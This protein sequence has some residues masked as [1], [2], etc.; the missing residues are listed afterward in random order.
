MRFAF[1]GRVSTEDHQDPVTSRARQ[2]DQAVALVGGHGRM[3]AEYVD[4]GHSRVLPWARRP[5]AA[6]LLVAMA[7]PERG[8]EAIVVKEY[9]R[10]FYGNQFALMAPL[11]EH[12]GVHLWM[13]ETGGPSTSPPKRT[14]N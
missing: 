3:V 2:R 9:E 14:N 12:Y 4:V 8:F 1:Y 6:A 10:A 7:D 11:F 13:P 5:E